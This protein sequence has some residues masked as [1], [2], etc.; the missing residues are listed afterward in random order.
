M[1]LSSSTHQLQRHHTAPPPCLHLPACL[2]TAPTLGRKEK[3][4][5]SESHLAGGGRGKEKILLITTPPRAGWFFLYHSSCSKGK[6]QLI[7]A[8][9][10]PSVGKQNQSKVRSE[11]LG[12]QRALPHPEHQ[13][14]ANSCTDA[15]ISALT[16]WVL[17]LQEAA[18][19][20]LP[21]S[22]STPL[23]T[24]SHCKAIPRTQMLPLSVK[25]A[26]SFCCH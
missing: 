9:E 13:L 2:G 11:L 6:Q 24:H 18:C 4:P 23:N 16:L 22:A 21:A 12:E 3:I 19:H 17:G 1:L 20:I 25:P 8:K 26:I 5:A 10:Q 14:T 7:L 15:H